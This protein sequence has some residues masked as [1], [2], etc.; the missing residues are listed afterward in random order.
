[1]NDF[2]TEIFKFTDFGTV[3]TSGQ[4]ATCLILSFVLSLIVAKVY[5]AT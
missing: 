3:V 1:M 4:I 5:Q 2:L